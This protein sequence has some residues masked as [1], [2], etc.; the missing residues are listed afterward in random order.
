[1]PS[2]SNL[3]TRLVVAVAAS[4]AVVL[5]APFLGQLR[6]YLRAA[7]PG[8]F[9]TIVGAALGMALAGAFAL[10]L[11]RIHYARAVRYGVIVASTAAAVA[12]ALATQS[13][14]PEVDVV[15]RVHFIEYG[16][17]A[18]LFYLAFRPLGD[19]AVVVL[20]ILA[21]LTVGTLDEWLQWFIPNR[22]LRSTPR[23]PWPRRCSRA[24]ARPPPPS[25]PYSRW[26]SPG[27]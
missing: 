15:E 22:A 14:V 25:V 3:N 10:A 9:V 8:Q 24:H 27:S 11:A 18:L 5:S 17:I 20:P 7:F 6:A 19:A 2:T 23:R 13:G 16:A 12:Y 4:A 26:S 1:M 21:A